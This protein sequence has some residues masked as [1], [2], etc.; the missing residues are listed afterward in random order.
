M[1]GCE[2]MDKREEKKAFPGLMDMCGAGK[3]MMPDGKCMDDAKHVPNAPKEMGEKMAKL[4]S[5]K[6]KK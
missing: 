4:R 5:L 3:H 6:L 1:P 2:L